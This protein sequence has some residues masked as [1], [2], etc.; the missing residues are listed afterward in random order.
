[1]KKASEVLT[2]PLFEN[3]QIS[4]QI[5]TEVQ[6]VAG[7]VER[8]RKICDDAVK[9]GS[10]S[11]LKPAERLCVYWFEPLETL[12]K[13]EIQECKD[14]VPGR[15]HRVVGPILAQLSADK[16]AVIVMHEALSVCMSSSELYTAKDAD[17][18]SEYRTGVKYSS[19]AYAVGRSVMA[20]IYIKIGKKSHKE[21]LEELMR[22]LRRYTS[23]RV[24]W[25]AN[26]TLN[27][28]K[29]SRSAITMVGDIL[30]VNLIDAASCSDYF[31]ED[32]VPA[33]KHDIVKEGKKDIGY[34]DRKS[35]V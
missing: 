13:K 3:S 26:K 20:E 25:W 33:F 28:E 27:C 12:I 23:K 15:N 35:V 6:A 17:G 21:S 4:K 32:F 8:Y 11:S 30:L 29:T 24:N 31:K 7:G 18:D 19:L 16:L 10:G 34:L 2:S 14:G 1:M 5:E 22:T 9:R